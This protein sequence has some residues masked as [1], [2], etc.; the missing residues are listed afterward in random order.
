M[1]AD[2]RERASARVGKAEGQRPSDKTRIR[3]MVPT[4]IGR[5]LLGALVVAAAAVLSA[6]PQDGK[7]SVAVLRSDGLLIPFAAYNGRAWNVPWPGAEPNVAL[8]IALDDVPKAWW[9][10][11]GPGA[12]WTAWLTAGEMRPLKLLR[13]V[14]VPIFCGGHLAVSTDYRGRPPDERAPTGQKD[15]IATAGDVKIQPIVEVSLLSGDAAAL[16]AAIT[17]KFNEEEELAAAHFTRWRHPF[18]R[19]MRSRLPIELEAFYRATETGSRGQFRTSYIE[20]VRKFPPLAGDE[21]CGLLTFARGWITEVPGKPPVINLGAR[22]TYC[23][24][25]EVS[26][27]L[28]FGRI[29][30]GTASGRGRQGGDT[31]WVYQLSSW[32][33]EFYSIARVAPDGVK[34]VVAVSGGG[35]PKE[36]GL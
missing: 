11:V 6:A 28:P 35:C 25:A 3:A 27:M 26:F 16:V 22:V 24:R 23:D 4:R 20:A 1:I 30:T 36:P 12:P 9:G 18:G 34:P 7:F 17:E 2:R 10:D 29:Q 21:G 14:H 32:R 5:A 8:P 15:G 19:V 31:F 13:P 33:D